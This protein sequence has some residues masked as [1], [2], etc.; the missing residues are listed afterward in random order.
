[1]MMQTIDTER[2]K[3]KKERERCERFERKNV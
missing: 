3:R 1:M 2:V